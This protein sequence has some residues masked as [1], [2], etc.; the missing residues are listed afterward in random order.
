MQQ[1]ERPLISI[2]RKMPWI[3]ICNLALPTSAV[4]PSWTV[5]CPC[6]KKSR[7]KGGAGKGVAKKGRK[8]GSAKEEEAAVDEASVDA[9]SRVEQEAR[10]EAEIEEI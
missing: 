10:P 6:S 3:W 8:G 9:T 1:S 5:Y 2:D 7:G 4:P